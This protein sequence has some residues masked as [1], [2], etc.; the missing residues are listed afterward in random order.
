M[1]VRQD[2]EEEGEGRRAGR[3]AW[4]EGGWWEVEVVRTVRD[5]RKKG[6]GGGA[7]G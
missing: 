3:S 4:K 5:R 7:R 1:R 6:G 2:G